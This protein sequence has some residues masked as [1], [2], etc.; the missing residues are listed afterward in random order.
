MNDI[1][2][3]ITGEN[4]CLHE[5]VATVDMLYNINDLITDVTEPSNN[6]TTIHSKEFDE[7]NVFVLE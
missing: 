5:S 2:Y 7:I 1:N 4:K 3:I 6:Y